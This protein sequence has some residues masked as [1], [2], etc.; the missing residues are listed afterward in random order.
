ML[1]TYLF[2]LLAVVGLCAF[3]AVFQMWLFRHDPDAERRS[4][5]CEGCNCQTH[6]D[7]TG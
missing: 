6:S 7:S 2:P 4:Q 1:T 3:W 5:K